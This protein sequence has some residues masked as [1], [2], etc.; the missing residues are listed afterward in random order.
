[1]LTQEEQNYI[2]NLRRHFHRHP[3]LS[4]KEYETADRIEYELK[5]FGV[6]THRVGE[7]GIVGT[8]CN[9]NAPS[10]KT[11]ALR[12]DI[13]ALPVTEKTGVTFA[14]ENPGVMHACGH[15]AHTA[16]LLGA[17]KRLAARAEHLNGTVKFFFQ[18]GEEI[19]AGAK[20]F[21]QNGELNGVD[22]ILAVH[23]CSALPVG[24]MSLRGGACSA[25]CD[26]FVIHVHGKSAHAATPHKSVDAVYIASQIA[27]GLQ[28]VVARETDP[29]DTGVVGVG[30]IQGGTSYNIV[31]E[32]ARLEG[33][34]RS[35][36]PAVREKINRRV[37]E[38]AKGTAAVYG[39]TADVDIQN[40]TCPLIN[41]ETV[42]AEVLKTAKALFGKDTAVLNYPKTMM[43]DD[44]AEFLQETKGMYVWVGSNDGPDSDTAYPHHHEKF[45]LN[46]RAVLAASELYEGYALN[47]LA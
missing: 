45:N 12:A 32:D 22:R 37:T 28:A 11:V 27:T 14:S 35:F 13:D 3:E 20:L 36:D 38:I 43:G 7:T 1:M 23:M 6:A 8:V 46:E 33:T 34:T 25:G 9:K 5:R 21:L 18:Q 10:K 4:M 29:L 44:F 42:A 19:C 24:K 30:I 41:D 17:A 40:Y 2:V 31:A 39:G 15:D 26:R 16:A 47:F